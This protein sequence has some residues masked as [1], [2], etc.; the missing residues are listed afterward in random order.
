MHPLACT[1]REVTVLVSTSIVGDL[2]MK[3]RVG[4]HT[5]LEALHPFVFISSPIPLVVLAYP[6]D[7][8]TMM[9]S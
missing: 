7:V 8:T 9:D 3:S 4:G 1:A 5:K 2:L 6:Y